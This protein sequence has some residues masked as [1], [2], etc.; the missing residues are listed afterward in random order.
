MRSVVVAGIDVV[1]AGL[2]CLAKN[3][4]GGIDVPRWSPDAGSGDTASRRT[5]TAASTSRGGPQTPGPAS[6][7]APYPMRFIFNDVAGRVKPPARSVCSIIPFL[8]ATII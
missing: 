8:L 5:A 4:N 3:S 1:H 6:C 7:I 2:Y